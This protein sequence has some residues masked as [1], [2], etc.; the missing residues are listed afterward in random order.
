[1]VKKVRRYQVVLNTPAGIS[2]QNY[3][4]YTKKKEAQAICDKYNSQES[5]P[6]ACWEVKQKNY[7]IR[8]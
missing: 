7:L 3:E 5:N 8:V 1:M 2:P 4:M 6:Y